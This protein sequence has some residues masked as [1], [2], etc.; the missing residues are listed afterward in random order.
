MSCTKLNRYTEAAQFKVQQNQCNERNLTKRLQ[1]TVIGLKVQ[2][3]QEL[4]MYVITQE[5]LTLKHFCET[6][7]F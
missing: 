6:V 4:L 1:M 5:L 3:I 2:N 7:N